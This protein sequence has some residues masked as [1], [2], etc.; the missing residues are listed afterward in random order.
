MLFFAGLRPGT[1]DHRAADRGD[2]RPG[3]RVLRVAA[4]SCVGFSRRA[5]S[6]ASCSSCTSTQLVVDRRA[7]RDPVR[8]RNEFLPRKLGRSMTEP[9]GRGR[10]ERGTGCAAKHGAPASAAPQ[11]EDRYY[12]KRTFWRSGR[13]PSSRCYVVRKAVWLAQS[14]EIRDSHSYDFF[15]SAPRAA[16]CASRFLRSPALRRFGSGSRVASRCRGLLAR[17]R[18]AMSLIGVAALV[19]GMPLSDT[20]APGSIRLR[21]DRVAS[22]VEARRTSSRSRSRSC[23]RPRDH[24]ALASRADA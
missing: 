9:R 24:A 17:L 16:R 11:P 15:W 19:I 5:F 23:R 22:L 21:G 6:R 1:G 4:L 18:I 14:D 3:L 13:D 7:A 12:V 10:G 20:V 8:R 2:S